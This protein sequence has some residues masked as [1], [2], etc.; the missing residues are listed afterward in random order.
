MLRNVVK[1]DDEKCIGCGLCTSACQEGALQLIDGKAKLLSDTYCD[2]LGV[3]LPNCPVGAITIEQRE[4]SAFD[5]EV[6]PKHLARQQEITKPVNTGGGCPGTRAAVIERKKVSSQVQESSQTAQSQLGQ[7][8]CQIKLVPVN[9][10]YFD[11]AHLL[12]A[13]DCTAFAYANIHNDFM[14]NKITLIGC[15]KLDSINYADKLTEILKAHQL[16][17]ITVLRMEKPCCGGIVNAVK[18]A[19]LNSGNMVPWRSVIIGTDGSIL[20]DC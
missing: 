1:I 12:I 9:A 5:K 10:P 7:W 11:N 14:R 17:S 8:P 6:A 20:E 16:K 15:P 4:A 2:G 3:C 13:A 18:E 19:L